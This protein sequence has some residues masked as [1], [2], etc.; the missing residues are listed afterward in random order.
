VDYADKLVT[1]NP[2]SD[3]AAD[4]IYTA[5]LT[6]AVTDLADNALTANFIW[7]FTTGTATAAG[8][9]P[10]NLRTAGDFAVLAKTGISKSDAAGTA[11]TG[12]IGVSP[13]ALTAITGFSQTM[14]SSNEF[15]TSTFVTGKIF[16]A[17]MTPPTPAKMTAA[18]SDMETAYTDAAGRTTP[19]VTE[20]GAGDISGKTLEP[21]LYKWG[22]GV[23]ITNAGVTLSGSDTDVW[24]F[25]IAG[26]LTVNNGAIVTLSGGALAKNIFWQVGGGVGVELGTTA[27][28]HGV[29]LAQKAITVNTDTTVSGRLLAQSAVTLEGNPVTQPAP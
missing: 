18:I 9:D 15:A 14:D 25:Q 10:V 5:T 13:E 24:I 6:T 21:G 2:A 23:L 16:A 7:T 19:D 27:Q 26:N 12:D 20:L 1:F 22:T 8:P 29:V 4:T 17:D 28:F 3:L 11:I